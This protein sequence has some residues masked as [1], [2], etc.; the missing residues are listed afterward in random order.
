MA[1]GLVALAVT[2]WVVGLRRRG[3][4]RVHRG[5]GVAGP[6]C[7]GR[8]QEQARIEALAS[9]CEQLRDLLSAEHGIIGTITATARHVPG[10]RSARR[11]SGWPPGCR[12]QSPAAAVRQFAAEVDDPAG[13]LI[14]SV[15]VVA[16]SRSSR[17]SEL[18]GELAVTIR[19]RA[20]MRLRV[21]AER[22]GQRCEARFVIGFAAVVIAGIVVFGRGSDFLDAYDTRHRP[23]GVGVVAAMFALGIRWLARLT[24]FGRPARF[25]AVGESGGGDGR[26]IWL[27]VAVACVFAGGVWLIASA[28]WPAPPPLSAALSRL[29]SA[30]PTPAGSSRWTADDRSLP[31]QLGRWLVRRVKASTLADERTAS[32]LE[33]L[34]RPLELYAGHRRCWRWWSARWPGRCCGLVAAVAGA[35]VAVRGA[36]VGRRSSAPP[37][38]GWCRGS[39]CVARRPGPAPISVT[40]WAPISTCWCCCSPPRRAR[41]R[42]WTWP[43]SAGQ[44]P[45]FAELRRAVWEARLSGEP[46]WETLD[47]LGRRL[48]IGELREIAAAGSL[49]GESGAAVR[50]S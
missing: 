9:W 33:V 3:C 32:D 43:P 46:V 20:A 44:G 50:K 23:A 15:L 14:A 10:A 8:R 18:L 11:W 36:A 30:A 26:V 41:R 40:P 31:A 6:R 34:Q 47:D 45:A 24:R 13:D 35:R 28:I 7:A 16:M 25:L 5:A 42:R 2:G 4:R 19:E 27:V 37:L 29:H 49:A 1:V 38:A 48:R 21:E 12:R 22:A 17:T 39:C